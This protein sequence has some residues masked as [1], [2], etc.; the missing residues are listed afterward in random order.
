MGGFGAGRHAQPDQEEKH[1]RCAD[2]GGG[3]E[4]LEEPLVSPVD[5]V[6]ADEHGAAFRH[7]GGGLDALEELPHR[8]DEQERR[9]RQDGNL[10]QP[11]GRAV[12]LQHRRYIF[13]V[14]RVLSIRIGCGKVRIRFLGE[15]GVDGSG[16]CFDGLRRTDH[17]DDVVG[18]SDD[19]DHWRDEQHDGDD[20]DGVRVDLARVDERSDGDGDGE[21][22]V[23][24]GALGGEVRVVEVGEDGGVP[25][26][27]EADADAQPEQVGGG[28]DGAVVGVGGGRGFGHGGGEV[29][30][31]R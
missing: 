8:G 12:P 26:D 30:W 10:T 21:A 27:V 14:V 18:E 11:V 23:D 3:G 17:G 29:R 24:G 6:G 9:R 13:R 28:F 5:V 16:W 25:L 31:G 1:Q 2:A 7:R 22:I 4:D 15:S 19:D 20:D